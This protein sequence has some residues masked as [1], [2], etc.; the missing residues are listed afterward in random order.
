MRKQRTY[1]PYQYRGTYTD[2]GVRHMEEANKEPSWCIDG[3]F[4]L[5]GLVIIW[6]SF[7]TDRI[8][9]GFILGFTLTFFSISALIKDYKKE[10]GLK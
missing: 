9:P 3:F 1:K 6:S 10:N 4:L 8:G 5:L 7:L 2:W